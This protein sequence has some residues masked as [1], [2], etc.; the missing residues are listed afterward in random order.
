MR[1]SALVLTPSGRARN[2]ARSGAWVR[3]EILRR[4]SRETGR[5]R[6]QGGAGPGDGQVVLEADAEF[7]GKVGTWLH[8]H[9]HSLLERLRVPFDEVR[10]FMDLEAQA[11][12]HAVREEFFEAASSE[13]DPS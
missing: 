13:D 12:T 11:V 9:R 3:S 10:R 1:S 5:R 2:G 4:L 8:R 6:E 7:P